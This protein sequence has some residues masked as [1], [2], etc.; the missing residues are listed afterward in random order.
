MYIDSMQRLRSNGRPSL[1]EII[2]LHDA[3]FTP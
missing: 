1:E 2:R 3:G